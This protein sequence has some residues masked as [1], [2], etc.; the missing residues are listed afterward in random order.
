[1]IQLWIWLGLSANRINVT[2]ALRINT[3]SRGSC[4]FYQ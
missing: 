1:M 3:A 4:E 2:F